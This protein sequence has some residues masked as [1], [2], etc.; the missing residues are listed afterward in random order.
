MGGR[1]GLGQGPASR[2]SCEDLRT[3][4]TLCR[5]LSV[6][7][8]VTSVKDARNI[9]YIEVHFKLRF[10]MQWFLCQYDI[11]V[12]LFDIRLINIRFQKEFEGFKR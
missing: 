5:E 7:V 1:C 4:W 2:P 10:S 11:R 6:D 12:M 9:K 8:P 3:E